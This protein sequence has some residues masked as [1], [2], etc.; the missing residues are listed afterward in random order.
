MIAEILLIGFDGG[1]DELD[2]LFEA[3]SAMGTVGL[4]TGITAALSTGSKLVIIIL[5]FLGRLGPITVAL[6]L[7]K[8]IKHQLHTIKY[9]VTDIIVG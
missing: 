1:I 5:M 2:L 6:A 8:K 4:S 9:P 3:A 7:K